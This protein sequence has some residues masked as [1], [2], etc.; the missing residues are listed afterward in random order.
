MVRAPS[1][2]NKPAM[3]LADVPLAHASGQ[4]V[5]EHLERTNLFVVPLDAQRQWY[6]YHHLFAD[7]LRR[8]LE[9]IRP[10]LVPSLHCRASQW[11]ERRG[12]ASEAIHHA[13]AADDVERAA[14]L[15]ERA[16]DATWM[17]SEVATFLRWVEALPVEIVRRRP[18][19]SIYHANALL[20]AGRPLDEVR[21]QLDEVSPPA[22]D[23]GDG[24]VAPVSGGMLVFRALVAAYQGKAAESAELSQQALE[25]LPEDSL[26]L[27]SLVAGI[28]GLAHLY[29]G[30]VQT[31]ERALE[32]AVNTS[33]KAGNLMNVVLALCHLAEISMLK[34]RLGMAKSRYDQALAWGADNQ[35]RLPPVAGIALTGLGQILLERNELEAA[36]QHLLE[37][38]QL[39]KKWGEAGTM[40][41]YHGLASLR[42]ARGDLV[43]AR[44]ALDT[45]QKIAIRFDAMDVDDLGVALQLAELS[46]AEGDIDA[47]MRW[48]A[49]RGLDTEEALARS[50]V[51]GADGRGGDAGPSIIHGFMTA[52]EALTYA[53]L[54]IALGRLQADAPG[55][56]T[57]AIDR[58][59]DLLERLLA[60]VE[61]QGWLWK[62]IEILVVY[63]LALE[64]QGDTTGA[65]ACLSRSLSL[66]EPEGYVRVF[67]NEGEPVKRLLRRAKSQG[68]AP[69]YVER[70]LAACDGRL[71]DGRLAD[72]GQADIPAPH[73]PSPGDL[74]LVESLSER[75]M[76]VMHMLTTHLSSTEI[77]DRLIISV[78]TVRSHIK[79]IYGKLDVHARDEAVQRA[80]EL[81][82][83]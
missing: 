29:G 45:A 76:E 49:E 38:I 3:S 61:P 43:G 50:E 7:L 74:G 71:A 64:V 82:L 34:G 17:R 46:L 21:A 60:V 63:A 27:R 6:R 5:L 1:Q 30:D 81:N 52:L 47:A 15:I 22:Q 32:D 53:R 19:L 28:L 13:L 35:G 9:R 26:F 73:L 70:L 42:Q 44:Q 24:A 58:A 33:Q 10:D 57:P 37:G 12:L 23:A 65:M 77:A 20:M 80:R 31:A 69:A 56:K 62:Q 4:E 25:L 54:L 55:S 8:R 67:V 79:N 75:E 68:V 48:A 16:A 18:M 51:L 83:I 59:T 66:A 78:N 72:G 41:G 40:R 14:Q 2:A 11:Y 39:A 36:E